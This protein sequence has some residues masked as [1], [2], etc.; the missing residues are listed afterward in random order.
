MELKG[1]RGD[2][3]RRRCMHASRARMLRGGTLRPSD[4]LWWF[5]DENE[6][7]ILACIACASPRCCVGGVVAREPSEEDQ[8]PNDAI[9]CKLAGN[10]DPKLDCWPMC[11]C[12]KFAWTLEFQPH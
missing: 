2:V 11:V 6:R 3:A 4:R 12:Q 5:N 10:K 7:T 8:E 9:T 1:G